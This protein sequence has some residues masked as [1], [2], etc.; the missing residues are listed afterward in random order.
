MKSSR[1]CVS[2][3]SGLIQPTHFA[4]RPL[5]KQNFSCASFN[6]TGT[7]RQM[8]V[9]ATLMQHLM[10]RGCT[11]TCPPSARVLDLG[12]GTHEKEPSRR[13][14]VVIRNTLITYNI[15]KMR[16]THFVRG[17]TSQLSFAGSA[18]ALSGLPNFGPALTYESWRFCFFSVTLEHMS[19]RWARYICT[20][21]L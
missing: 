18:G 17:R 5:A 4:K 12:V 15:L 8:K 14:P 3:V 10:T 1:A 7:R 11:P 2:A 9:D 13:L 19:W 6:S 16:T 21:L 20:T